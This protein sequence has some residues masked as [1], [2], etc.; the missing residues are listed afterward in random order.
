MTGGGPNLL[1]FGRCQGGQPS[2]IP[3]TVLAAADHTTAVREPLQMDRQAQIAPFWVLGVGLIR[4]WKE[5]VRPPS[6]QWGLIVV[7]GGLLPGAQALRSGT[8]AT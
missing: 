5:V 3:G 6:R 1:V 7:C 4:L 2:R 8:S